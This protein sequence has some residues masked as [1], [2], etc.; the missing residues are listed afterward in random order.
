MQWVF[1]RK[2]DAE[3]EKRDHKLQGHRVDIGDFEV[4]CDLNNSSLGKSE[5]TRRLAAPA[6][7]WCGVDGLRCQ[8]LQ[9]L[10]TQLLQRHWEWQED[11]R[12]NVWHGSEK[13]PAMYIV[14]MDI[15]TAVDVARSK[16]TAQIMGD[17]DV[18]GWITAALLHEMTGHAIIENVQSKFQCTRCF[19][20]GSVEA[21]TLW[22]KLAMQI[23]WCVEKNG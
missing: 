9:V 7:G 23:L 22:F 11:K 1:L 8:H 20:Q 18:H 14:S 19:R 5:R 17:Q 21:P 13:K 2:P 3:L 15:K 16:R 4:V 12:T 6:R 10:M